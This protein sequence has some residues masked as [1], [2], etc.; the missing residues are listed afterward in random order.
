MS[1]EALI[2]ANGGFATALVGSDEYVRERVGQ[3][4]AAGV[5]LM[6]CQFPTMVEDIIRFSN[7][8]LSTESTLNNCTRQTFHEGAN[9]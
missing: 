6:L 9:A 2:D 4:E 7:C 3:Y 8:T 5:D 1:D